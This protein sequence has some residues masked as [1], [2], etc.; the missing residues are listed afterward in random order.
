MSRLRLNKI[1]TPAT[2]AANKGELFLSSTL[3]PA[4]PAFIDESGVVESLGHQT[5]K[6]TADLGA[7]V[8]TV[9]ADATGLLL[10]VKN[11]VYYAFEFG[12]LWTTATATTG[13]KI[14]LTIP[15]ATIYSAMV[16]MPVAA[17]GAAAEWTGAL[18][19]SGDSTL[20]SGAEATGTV[21]LAQ[22]HG[23]ILPSADGNVQVQYAAEVGAAGNVVVKQGSYGI[24]R[25]V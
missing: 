22:I 23:V 19:A 7:S 10:A 15:A 5:V 14:G 2:P 20:G 6:I 17:D 25:R 4:R 11:G 21:Y 3:S 12:V 1:A 24:A 8:S 13:L 16:N 18:T 9:L